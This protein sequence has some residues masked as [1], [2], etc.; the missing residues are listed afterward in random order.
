[1]GTPQKALL[2]NQDGT[3]FAGGDK[4]V[5]NGAESSLGGAVVYELDGNAVKLAIELY[6]AHAATPSAT[7]KV[8]FGQTTMK[9][10]GQQIGTITTDE[11]GFGELRWEGTMNERELFAVDVIHSA[12]DAFVST[13]DPRRLEP[14]YQDQQEQWRWNN[15]K[16]MHYSV[17][18]AELIA[19]KNAESY[20]F[21]EFIRDMNAAIGG[22]K[23][24]PPKKE[25]IIPTE[26]EIEER[27]AESRKRAGL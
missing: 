20:G 9:S 26:A 16:A 8:W 10:I 13:A 25:L 4:A 24:S 3:G 19:E 7:Y 27:V 15:V 22:V 21:I 18:R 6:A 12:S 2:I 5:W 11:R 17:A 14:W 1:M 23:P